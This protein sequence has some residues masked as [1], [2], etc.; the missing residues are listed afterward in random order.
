MPTIPPPNLLPPHPNLR[1]HHTLI[2]I[3]RQPQ[4]DQPKIIIQR[5][6]VQQ[7]HAPPILINSNFQIPVRV[8]Q[9]ALQVLDFGEVQGR[10]AVVV[11]VEGVVGQ[12]LQVGEVGV[13][14]HG[15]EVFEHADD[16]VAGVVEDPVAVEEMGW[17]ARPSG[18]RV[19]FGLM[20]R[21]TGSV[22]RP[23]IDLGL[24]GERAGDS[25]LHEGT[26]GTEVDRR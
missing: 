3:L 6:W 26:P 18:L 20:L 22:A 9:L 15:F 21:L 23:S 1:P 5:L 7:T 19:L 25:R 16:V 2:P 14:A 17:L 12:G 10:A 4:T 13:V 11:L 24:A 8:A